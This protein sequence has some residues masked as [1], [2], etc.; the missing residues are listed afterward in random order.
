MRNADYVACNPAPTPTPAPLSY[1]PHHKSDMALPTT[2]GGVSVNF[3]LS[4]GYRERPQ[5]V[6]RQISTSSSTARLANVEMVVRPPA[7]LDSSNPAMR[8]GPSFRRLQSLYGNSTPTQKR[9]PSDN[10][11]DKIYPAERAQ[12]Q[13]IAPG[14]KAGTVKIQVRS[15]SAQASPAASP[16]HS[17]RQVF[18][19]GYSDDRVRS[20]RTIV[21]TTLNRTQ[22]S[23]P[24]ADRGRHISSNADE[25]QLFVEH[26]HATGPQIC[27]MLCTM[28]VTFQDD[29]EDSE[30]L[31]SVREIIRQ[32]EEMTQKNCNSSSLPRQPSQ[33]DNSPNS[34]SLGHKS[35]ASGRTTTQYEQQ[36]SV[37]RRSSSQSYLQSER[38]NAINEYQYP[39]MNAQQDDYDN[40]IVPNPVS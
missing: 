20:Q 16:A 31:P 29:D 9:Y 25:I 14:R 10:T 23:P 15:R 18:N 19:Q 3:H 36:N 2:G 38:Q 30:A 24:K 22:S 5:P 32:V 33:A 26:L 4:Q 37:Q 35:R 11:L 17:P 27:L 12:P 7:A 40:P 39:S 21:P 6:Q 8:G 1:Q 28:P 34:Q 13:Y